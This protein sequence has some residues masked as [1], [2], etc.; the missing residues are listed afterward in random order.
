MRPLIVLEDGYK[1]VSNVEVPLYSSRISAIFTKV[2]EIDC[3]DLVFQ[4]E[5]DP[6]RTSLTSA[7]LDATGMSQLVDPFRS[8]SYEGLDERTM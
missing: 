1:V 2:Y 3:N 4:R 6:R 7:E 8:R 5:L